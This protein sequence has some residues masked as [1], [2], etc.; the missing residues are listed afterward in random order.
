MLIRNAVLK[1]R[2]CTC[3]ITVRS[4]G[5][6]SSTSN[7]LQQRKLWFPPKYQS[8]RQI[9]I[10]NLDTI[11]EKKLNIVELHPDIFATNPRIDLIHQNVRWQILYRYVSFAHTKVRSEVRGGGRKPWPQKGKCNLC[12]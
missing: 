11:D 8:P 3:N 6:S 5:I 7:E 10:E 4:R 2:N 1:L 9:W 12:F